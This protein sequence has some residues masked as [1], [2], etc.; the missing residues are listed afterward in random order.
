MR[1]ANVQSAGRHKIKPRGKICRTCRFWSDVCVCVCI[2]FDEHVLRLCASI[3]WHFGDLLTQSINWAHITGN[4]EMSLFIA[5]TRHWITLLS[6][7]VHYLVCYFFSLCC[8][9]C[10]WCGCWC[11]CSLMLLSLFTPFTPKCALFA[12]NFTGNGTVSF[13]L[14]MIIEIHIYSRDTIYVCVQR[15]LHIHSTKHQCFIIII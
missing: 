12:H 7:G 11:C 1:R 6:F 15:H 2:G 10:C 4:W 3:V 14:F 13:N 9:C 5:A 8:C